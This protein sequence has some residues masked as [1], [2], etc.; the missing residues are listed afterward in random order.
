MVSLYSKSLVFVHL[1]KI[2]PFGLVF[3]EAMSCGTPVIACK[4]GATEEIIQHGETGFLIHENDSNSLINCVE[5]LLD[6]P[7]SSIIMGQK[8]KIE[9]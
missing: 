1:Q 7:G 5:K 2:H 3:I 4:P 6:D 9:S 8:R